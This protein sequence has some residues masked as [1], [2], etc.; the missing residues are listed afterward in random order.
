MTCIVYYILWH[1]CSKQELGSQQKQL[2]LGIGSAN[3]TVARQCLGGRHV[4]VTTDAHATIEAL[5]EAIRPETISIKPKPEASFLKNLHVHEEKIIF[6]EI[7]TRPE[8][9]IVL[10]RTDWLALD[11]QERPPVGSG[12][13][14][15]L[16]DN[17]QG[18]WP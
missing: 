4:R 7:P 12:G 13:Q 1:V 18:L 8:T 15:R 17:G 6:V 11:S 16:G 9:M 10:A 14:T 5:L 2:L 3:T